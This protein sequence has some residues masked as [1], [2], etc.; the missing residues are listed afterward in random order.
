[1]F[2]LAV[3]ALESLLLNPDGKYR[4][5]TLSNSCKI[6]LVDNLVGQV[7]LQESADYDHHITN[8]EGKQLGR[9][10]SGLQCHQG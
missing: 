4:L 5:C 7:L 9:L 8:P 3:F 2:L 6:I 1:M 10:E